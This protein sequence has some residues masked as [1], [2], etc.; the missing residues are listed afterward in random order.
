MI[1]PT[2]TYGSEIW[3]FHPA[4]DIERVH[5]KFLK[6]IFCVKPQTS[7]ITVHGELGRVPLSIIRK[8]RILKYWYKLMKFQIL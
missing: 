4:S 3:R 1:L 2:L 5:L 8:E 6:Q 7:N